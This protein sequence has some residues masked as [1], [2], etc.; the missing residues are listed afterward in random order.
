M[1]RMFFVSA[2]ILSSVL[3]FAQTTS[4][5]MARRYNLIVSQVGPSGLGVETVLNAWEKVD[6]TNLDMLLGRFKF[7][8]SGA[9]STNVVVKQEKKYLGMDP[10]LNLK[11]TLGREVYYF[12]EI[13]YD[14]ELFGK[15]IKVLDKAATLYP[16]RLDLRAMKAN[17]YITYEKGSPDLAL[18][19]LIALASEGAARK[20]DW[21]FEGK[22]EGREFFKSAMQEYCYNL[23]SIGTGPSRKAFFDLSVHLNRLFPESVDFLNNV[24]SYHL[25]SKDYKSALKCYS[26]VLKKHPEDLTALQNSALAARLLKNR[27]LEQKYLQMIQA[28]NQK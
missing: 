4:E 1:K 26:K 10:I 27:K 22:K 23:F 9:Q 12:Q 14:D 2:L 8:L 19:Y 13:N 15:A 16:D 17:L 7:Y 6:S 24:G 5:L 28:L 20:E 18:D 11:D 21:D 25:V 3:S